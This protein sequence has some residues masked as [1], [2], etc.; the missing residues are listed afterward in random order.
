MPIS[1]E[2]LATAKKAYSEIRTCDAVRIILIFSACL[3]TFFILSFGISLACGMTVLTHG[4]FLRGWDAALSLLS[5]PRDYCFLVFILAPLLGQVFTYR[6]FKPRYAENLKIVTELEQK[7]AREL[8]YGL[9]EE[10][11][12]EHPFLETL[13]RKLEKRAILWR[14]DAFLSRKPVN[15]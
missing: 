1:A 2:E 4:K 14:L 3:Y 8:P 10:F 9:E 6:R 15:G 7:H 11:R 5:E 12:R 13:S